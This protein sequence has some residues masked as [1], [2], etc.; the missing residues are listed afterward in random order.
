MTWYG[1]DLLLLLFPLLLLELLLVE[2]EE[3][4]SGRA[5]RNVRTVDEDVVAARALMQS[6]TVLRVH[7]VAMSGLV[8]VLRVDT[9]HVGSNSR[10]PLALAAG[11]DNVVD[12]ELAGP[13]AIRKVMNKYLAELLLGPFVVVGDVFIRELDDGVA[14]GLALAERNDAA[15]VICLDEALAILLK[16]LHSLLVLE[17]APVEL[18]TLALRQLVDQ[19]RV[20]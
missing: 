11:V 7:V 13:G 19:F 3:R 2:L 9:T 1:G 6:N 17:F 10:K 14:G 12:D 20:A 18:L 16:V 5:L 15:V 4:A 8:Q